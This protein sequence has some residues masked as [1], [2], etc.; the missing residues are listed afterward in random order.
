MLSKYSR[1]EE[2]FLSLI[3]RQRDGKKSSRKDQ[4]MR[5]LWK[6]VQGQG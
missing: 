1:A 5:L 4:S 6:D 2:A 3:E